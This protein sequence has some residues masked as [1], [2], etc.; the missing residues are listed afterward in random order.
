MLAVDDS[1]SKEALYATDAGKLLLELTDFGY[2]NKMLHFWA[3]ATTEGK[4]K[5][6]QRS[7]SAAVS[8]SLM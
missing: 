8:F 6:C 2:V 7:S 4:F 5:C 1:M 3:D